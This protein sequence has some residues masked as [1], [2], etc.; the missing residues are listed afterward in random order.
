MRDA[1]HEQLDSITT[2]LVDMTRLAGS[3]M[4]RATTALLDAD[5]H[6]AEDVITG[7]RTLDHA[8]EH[9]DGL[10]IDVL[11]RQQ[12]VATDL[13]TV[14]TAL[15]MSGD[16]ERMGDLARHVA[17][18]ARLRFPNSAVPASLRAHILQMGQVAE[19]VVTKSGSII[20]ARDVAEAVNIE[21]DDDVMDDLH[22]RL[23]T[24]LATTELPTETIVDLTLLGRYYERFA[25]HAVSVARRVVYLVTGE[26]VPES[27]GGDHDVSEEA[28][29]IALLRRGMPSG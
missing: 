4:A 24:V 15:R 22:R 26:Y 21:R 18:V 16:L 8:R 23:F 10:A 7:D 6:L 25:D 19:L 12:P 28:A 29:R 2:Q 5:L 9:L 1:F 27:S 13:R 17:K 20:A 3:A 11:A 14:V